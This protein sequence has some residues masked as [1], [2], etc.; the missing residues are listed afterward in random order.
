MDAIVPEVTIRISGKWKI[1]EPWLTPG[2]ERSGHKCQKLYKKTL[3]QSC[4]EGDI[5]K[6]KMYRNTLT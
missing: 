4:A 6:Y 1:H 5:Q 3:T 2:L